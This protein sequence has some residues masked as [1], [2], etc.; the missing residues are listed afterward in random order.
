LQFPDKFDGDIFYSKYHIETNSKRLEN[1]MYY[2][3]KLEIKDKTNNQ[4]DSFMRLF[5]NKTRKSSWFVG[6]S[7]LA[8]AACGG[9]GGGTASNNSTPAN[10]SIVPPIPDVVIDETAEVFSF[11]EQ[12]T[13]KVGYTGTALQK[14]LLQMMI[15]RCQLSKLLQT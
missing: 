13:S 9:G 8:L 7:P 1:N 3:R 14:Q 11:S 15:S 6:T 12:F 2:D 5:R 10:E 4:F